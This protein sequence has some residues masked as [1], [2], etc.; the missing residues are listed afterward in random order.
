M[1]FD[2]AQVAHLTSRKFCSFNVKPSLL[3][4]TKSGHDGEGGGA[5]AGMASGFTSLEGGGVASILSRAT[6]SK[7]S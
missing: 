4:D 1:H 7:R 5:D 3:S 6:A 2:L